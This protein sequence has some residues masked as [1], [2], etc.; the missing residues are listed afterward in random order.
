MPVPEDFGVDDS[1]LIEVV[2]PN[3]L[4]AVKHP[5]QLIL[6]QLGCCRYSDES[7]FA[8][9]LALEE[10]LTNGVKHG[11]CSDPTKHLTVRF[12][13]KPD[14]AVIMI[15][16]EGS[17]FCPDAVPDPTAE[18]NLQRPNGRGIMLMNAY[19]TRVH[20]NSRGNEVWLMKENRPSARGA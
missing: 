10:A 5:E 13:V 7:V 9:K 20:Y 16:D 6:T 2:V 11:N 15:R 1:D 12:C 17:G 4:R 8:I 18:E 19:M 3:D 14:R